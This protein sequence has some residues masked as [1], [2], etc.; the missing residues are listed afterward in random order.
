MKENRHYTPKLIGPFLLSSILLWSENI[1][2][3]LILAS[4]LILV[5][6]LLNSM[7]DLNIGY[8]LQYISIPGDSKYIALYSGDDF[9]ITATIL[10]IPFLI[11][12]ALYILGW[13]SMALVNI[14]KGSKEMT[15]MSGI[16]LLLYFI[17]L[18]DVCFFDKVYNPDLHGFWFNVIS[19]CLLVI[20]FV[21]DCGIY[22]T[23]GMLR[24]LEMKWHEIETKLIEIN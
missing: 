2:A 11:I 12:I 24:R 1:L 18:I 20:L 17:T 8:A 5:P 22:I 21:I 13:L 9:P 7:F 14:V 16:N 4:T 15:I 3:S 23:V 19:V 10:I 6:L